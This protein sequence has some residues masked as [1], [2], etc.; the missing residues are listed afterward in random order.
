M[1]LFYSETKKIK[2]FLDPPP[3]KKEAQGYE[4]SRYGSKHMC[5]LIPA[6]C[7][8]EFYYRSRSSDWAQS[9]PFIRNY[10]LIIVAFSGPHFSIYDI[11]IQQ[12]AHLVSTKG[13]LTLKI[14]N[15]CD[16]L[17]SCPTLRN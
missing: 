2:Y 12:K 10:Y 17:S 15:L 14:I 3:P 8:L 9:N 16:I 13:P 1:M 6:A 7:D 11:F 4:R 5:L